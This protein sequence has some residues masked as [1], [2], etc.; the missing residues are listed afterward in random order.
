VEIV[1]LLIRQICAL[2]AVRWCV[3]VCLLDPDYLIVG[4]LNI[5]IGTFYLNSLLRTHHSV[6]IILF[7]VH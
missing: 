1:A 2:I 7:V 6:Q 4:T 5:G 3:C